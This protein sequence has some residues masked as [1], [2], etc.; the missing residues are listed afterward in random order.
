MQN[1][2][3]PPVGPAAIECNINYYQ[4]RIDQLELEARALKEHLEF[5]LECQKELAK[6]H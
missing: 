5:W 3:I 2:T 4:S 6:E 1:N